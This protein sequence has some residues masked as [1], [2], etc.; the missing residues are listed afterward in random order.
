MIIYVDVDDT[1]VRSVGSRRIPMPAVVQHVR[2]LKE[3]GAELYC[4]SS[5]GAEYAR[6]SAEE[7]GI[8]ECFVAF[9]PKPQV[10]LDDQEVSE[11]RTCISVHPS[12]C[13]GQDLAAYRRILRADQGA[14]QH[15]P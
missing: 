15:E 10:I 4:W 3:Q 5:G 2:D 1:L 11:W 8:V 9:L 7:L 12:S 6:R 13:G 14:A